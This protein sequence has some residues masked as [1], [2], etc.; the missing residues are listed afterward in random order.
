M[1]KVGGI[2]VEPVAGR[3]IFFTSEVKIFNGNFFRG[4]YPRNPYALRIQKMYMKG[5][6]NKFL[7]LFWSPE[8]G[9]VRQN[10]VR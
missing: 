9:W 1:W 8:V 10:G 6:Y 2:K 5:G 3:R 4:K 7:T